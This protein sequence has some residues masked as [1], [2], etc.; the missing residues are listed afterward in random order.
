MTH[1]TPLILPSL[2]AADWSKVAAEVKR[3]EEVGVQWLHLDVMD[4]AFVDNISFGPQM[5]QTVRK[6]TDMY[7]DVHLM[8]HRPDHFLE[9]F[10]H[11]GADNI[12]I[13]V[14]A[15]YDTSVIE[16]L[17]RI[18]AAGKHA[19]I[20]LHPDTPFEAAIPYAHEID[21]L[22]V[23]TVVPGFGGQPFMEKQTM[24]KLA[25]ARDYRDAHGLK[26]HLEVDGGI[27]TNTAPI[28]KANGANLFVCGTSFYGPADTPQAMAELTACVA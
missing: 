26:Y 12:T 5:V 18:R 1:D 20:A 19:G 15:R 11:A 24:P 6:C 27:Y 17:R 9:R 8:I 13:H 23:M 14:E 4:G 21:L 22:L 2:L 10:L 28:A 3:A 16:T 7:L 25:A